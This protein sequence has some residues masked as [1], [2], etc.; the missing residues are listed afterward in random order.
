MT[1]YPSLK[2]KQLLA[3]LTSAPLDY[4]VVR[5]AGSHRRLESEKYPPL[6]FSFHDRTTIPGGLVRRILIGQVGL[7]EQEARSLL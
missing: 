2:A 5:Q 7:D 6:T 3:V 1:R 4:E